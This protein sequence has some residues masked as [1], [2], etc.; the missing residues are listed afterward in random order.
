VK[1]QLLLFVTLLGIGCGQLSSE[2]HVRSSKN[3]SLDSIIN[4]Y[5]NPSD[6]YVMVIA[7]RAD[8]RNFPENSLEAIRSAIKL[9]VDMV[10][11]DVRKTKDGKLILMHDETVDRTTCTIK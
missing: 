3:I 11:I 5:K 1:H 7:H 2:E 8:W 6:H 9:G 10:E 4:L